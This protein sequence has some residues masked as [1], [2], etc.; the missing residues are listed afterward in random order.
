MG[1]RDDESSFSLAGLALLNK[2]KVLTCYVR[3]TIMGCNVSRVWQPL[4]KASSLI[5]RPTN[6]TISNIGASEEC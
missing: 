6:R 2:N 3:G 5:N 4:H 1:N